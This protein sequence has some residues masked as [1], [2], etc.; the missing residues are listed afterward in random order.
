MAGYSVSVLSHDPP[1]TCPEC[2]RNGILY[3][4][5]DLATR[6]IHTACRGCVLRLAGDDEGK[7]YVRT[8]VRSVWKSSTRPRKITREKQNG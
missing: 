4:A 3:N 1:R 5:Q 8:T 2:R 6:R 7:V